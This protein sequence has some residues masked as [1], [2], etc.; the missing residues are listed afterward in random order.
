MVQHFLVTER[1]SP[2]T[3]GERKSGS[4]LMAVAFGTFAKYAKRWDEP[5]LM[6]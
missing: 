5:G 3:L 6:K 1:P 4:H 2:N